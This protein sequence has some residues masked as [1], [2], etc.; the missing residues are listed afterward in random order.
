MKEQACHR[1]HAPSVLGDERRPAGPV[2]MWGGRKRC[3]RPCIRGS[4]RWMQCAQLS[5]LAQW[6]ACWAH[7]PKVRGSKPRSA[8]RALRP[9]TVV[10][11]WRSGTQASSSSKPAAECPCPVSWG[12]LAGLVASSPRGRGQHHT[13]GPVPWLPPPDA[14]CIHSGLAQW[15]ACWADNPKVRGSKP[16]SAT[17][18]L[19]PPTVVDPWRSGTQASSSSEPAAECPC[20]V[21]WGLLAGLVGSTPQGRGQHHTT[22]RVPWVPPPDA[23][24]IHSG[25]AQW[26]ACWA[27]NPKV[28]GSKPRSATWK[29]WP[30]I[31]VDFV[32][33][34]PP[35]LK[36]QQAYQGMRVPLYAGG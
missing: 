20:P 29:L 8:T 13:T 31:A 30:S 15:L 16:R 27:H 32:E 3:R 33:L 6:S 23:V 7:N 4:G 9:P 10:E 5:G 22:G 34:W 1:V 18:A 21:S 19:R 26:L 28:R 36:K 17:R 35:G 14:I 11:S 24:C 2:T 12:L 25:L